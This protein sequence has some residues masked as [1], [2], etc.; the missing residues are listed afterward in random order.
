MEK[1]LN[2]FRAGFGLVEILFTLAI[3]Y[4]LYYVTANYY[5]KKTPLG[6][7][8]DTEKFVV[9]QGINPTSYKTIVDTVKEKLSKA[10]EEQDKRA[11]ELENVQ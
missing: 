7:N 10:S 8:K 6:A 2:K 1:R 11:K 4:F 3:I 9:Q 5:F